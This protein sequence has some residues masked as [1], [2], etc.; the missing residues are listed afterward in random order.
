[1]TLVAGL[2]VLSLALLAA[3]LHNLAFAALLQDGRVRLHPVVSKAVGAFVQH[4]VVGSSA[5]SHTQCK[6]SENK[7]A[8]TWV[9]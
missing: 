3:I 8:G 9:H 6:M 1:M 2:P 4:A 5:G 7:D